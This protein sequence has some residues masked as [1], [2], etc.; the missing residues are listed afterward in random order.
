[1]ALIIGNYPQNIKRSI[2]RFWQSRLA[3][4]KKQAAAGRSDQGNRSAVTGGK[5]LDGIADICAK[6]VPGNGLKAATIHRQKRAVV[7]P[8]YFRPT[9]QW[10]LLVTL[11]NRLIAVL[12]FKSLCGPS[13]GNNA[14]NRCEE[15]LGSA[16]DFQTAVKEG[17]F[18]DGAKPF[19][20]YLLLI[21]DAEKSR[22]PVQAISPH[23]ETN[24]RFIRA[25]YIERMNVLC[26]RMMQEGLYDA[27]ALIV[28]PKSGAGNG[29]FTSASDATSCKRFLSQFAGRIAAEVA[30]AL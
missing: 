12:E 20:G 11:R 27:A 15:A 25:S 29:E 21:E 8:G 9:K 3:A 13:F 7:L 24:S 23:F 22:R 18:G 19:V 16:V 4:V 28:S 1:M 2:K 26:E 10:D 14:N 5:N 17:A 30:A 6:L